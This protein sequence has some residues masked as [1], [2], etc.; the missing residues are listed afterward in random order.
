MWIMSWFSDLHCRSYQQVYTCASVQRKRRL[1]QHAIY[2]YMYRPQEIDEAARRRLVKRLYIP[3]PD[4][5]ARKQIVSNL[6]R[7]QAYSLAPEELEE[8]S[9]STDGT[10]TTVVQRC[11]LII[12]YRTY[13][14]YQATLGQTWPTYVVRQLMDQ[15]EKQLRPSST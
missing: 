7:E 4:G 2:M 5:P 14:L 3:L 8:L 9:V 11:N 6:L 12:L 10:I 13:P 1:L 15:S